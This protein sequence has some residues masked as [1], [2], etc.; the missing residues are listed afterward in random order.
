MHIPLAQLRRCKKL[1][2][3]GLNAGK[4]A[5]LGA[6]ATGLFTN[7]VVSEEQAKALLK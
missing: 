5:L 7:L 1:I 2:G 4:K 6:L 3:I